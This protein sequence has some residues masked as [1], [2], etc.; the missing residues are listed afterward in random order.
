[1]KRGFTLLELI[2]VIIILGVLAVLGFTQYARIIERSRGAEAKTILG[3]I[4][5]LGAGYYL[6]FVSTSD[7][8]TGAGTNFI[9]TAA[10]KI[11]SACRGSH[12]FKYSVAAGTSTTLT[13]T[14]TRCS[15]GGKPPQGGSAGNMTVILES[16]FSTGSDTWAGTGG[17]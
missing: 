12:W 16:D 11:P 6:E 5:K 8:P 4:R 9:G 7:F 1:M 14:A 10:D 3:D 17:Y 13:G 2:V 15:A